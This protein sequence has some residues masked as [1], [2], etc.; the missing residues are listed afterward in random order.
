MS[1]CLTK[2]I[3]TG[4]W[5]CTSGLLSKKPFKSIMKRA[6]FSL[7]IKANGV[8]FKKKLIYLF[9]FTSVLLLHIQSAW[10]NIRHE[11]CCSFCRLWFSVLKVFYNRLDWWMELIAERKSWANRRTPINNILSHNWWTNSLY[12]KLAGFY[13]LNILSLSLIYELLALKRNF[14]CSWCLIAN[15]IISVW[16]PKKSEMI[17][18]LCIGT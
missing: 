7:K 17:R 5:A 9:W 4:K 3:S 6:V 1:S 16:I 12:L 13:K 15:H 18:C 11:I 14:C 2:R 8:C 10:I